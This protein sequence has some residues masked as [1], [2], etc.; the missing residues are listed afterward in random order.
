MPVCLVGRQRTA[1]K[2]RPEPGNGRSSRVPSG[3]ALGA[4]Q[5]G[6]VSHGTETVIGVVDAQR[7][8][9]FRS[10]REHAVGLGDATRDQIVDHHPKIGLAA[11][12]LDS[13]KLPGLPCGIAS[14]DKPLGGSLFVACRAVDLPGQKQPLNGFHLQRRMQRA[15]IDIVILDGVTWPQD[16]CLLQP[17]DALDQGFLHAF[18]QRGRNAVR[19]DR[20]IVEPLWLQK[21]LMS[22]TIAKL[23]NLV[24]NGRTVSRANAIDLPTIHGR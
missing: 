24:L 16:N 22:I 23:D 12:K 21:H 10:G 20:I 5:P 18:R 9:K 3:C 1:I 4:Y 19:I 14:R 13:V 7:Q 8:A 2:I 6:P 15:R 11:V 17:R